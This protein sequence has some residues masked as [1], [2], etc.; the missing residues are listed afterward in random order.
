MKIIKA[1]VIAAAAVMLAGCGQS[2]QPDSR[3]PDAAESSS[4]SSQAVTELSSAEENPSSSSGETS[5][6]VQEGDSSAAQSASSL[7]GLAEKLKAEDPEI[8]NGSAVYGSHLFEHNCKKL[9]LCEQSDLLDGFIVYNDSGG[10][11]DEISVI[12]RA[13]GDTDKAVRILGNRKDLRYS[14]FKGYVPE[15]LPKIEAGRAFSVGEWAVLIISDKA[16][17]L[18]KIIREE[19]S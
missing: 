19:L 6:A 11:A 14:D 4:V 3:S 7:E 8:L 17:E 15:E 10:K 1:A 13:D 5:S 16:D 18:E 12:K 2:S 9:Y